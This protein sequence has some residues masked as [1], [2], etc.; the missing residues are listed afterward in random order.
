MVAYRRSAFLS[1]F[2][3][4][5]KGGVEAKIRFISNQGFLPYIVSDFLFH[6]S[7][8]RYISYAV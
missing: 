7:F 6:D 1:R 2:F 3:V 5:E 8:H 4:E